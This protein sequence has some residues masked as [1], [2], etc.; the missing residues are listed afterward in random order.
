MSSKHEHHDSDS[1]M[2]WNWDSN[3]TVIFKSLS[4]SSSFGLFILCLLVI[5]LGFISRFIELV[6]TVQNQLLDSNTPSINKPLFSTLI[7]S[8]RISKRSIKS[9]YHGVSTFTHCLVMLIFMTYNGFIIIS[10][11]IGASLGF[12]I[13]SKEDDQEDEVLLRPSI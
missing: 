3:A 6:I 11:V 4:S 12:Y 2:Y 13:F 10:F 8:G 9:I 7:E 1:G 5:F